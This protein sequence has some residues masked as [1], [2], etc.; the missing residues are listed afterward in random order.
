MQTSRGS[1]S[2]VGRGDEGCGGK[3]TVSSMRCAGSRSLRGRGK[4]G[5]GS[6]L[7]APLMPMLFDVTVMDIRD[8][9]DYNYTEVLD[10]CLLP[11]QLPPQLPPP[12]PPSSMSLLLLKRKDT[13]C[14]IST[15]MGSSSAS[16]IAVLAPAS[17]SGL[18]SARL[19]AM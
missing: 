4:L 19:L 7:P 6:P 17:T 5:L 15:S 3:L 16:S 11:P 10:I 8:V 13:G 18:A 12:E 2:S 1:V 9:Q 14:T